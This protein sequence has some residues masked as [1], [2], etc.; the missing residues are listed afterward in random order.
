MN[1]CLQGLILILEKEEIVSVRAHPLVF[2]V[3]KGVTS[4]DY[5]YRHEKSGRM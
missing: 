3:S 1:E 4:T 2:V 5:I